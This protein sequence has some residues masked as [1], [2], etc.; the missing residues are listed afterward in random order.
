MQQFRSSLCD[1]LCHLYHHL[2]PHRQRFCLGVDQAITG[3]GRAAQ[4]DRRGVKDYRPATSDNLLE[5]GV[6]TR[7]EHGHSG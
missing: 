4:M 6:I 2:G 7:P 3:L 1:I 5:P